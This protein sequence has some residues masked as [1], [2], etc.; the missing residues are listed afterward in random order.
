M[1]LAGFEPVEPVVHLPP[2]TRL[3][4]RRVPPG[5]CISRRSA[6]DAFV[7]SMCG[8]RVCPCFDAS[9]ELEPLCD[10]C[11]T[12]AVGDEEVSP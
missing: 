9:T 5:A 4:R 10:D 12:Q 11:W 8:R 6:R 1:T 3:G 7:C 2:A